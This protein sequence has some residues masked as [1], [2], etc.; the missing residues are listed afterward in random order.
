[1]LQGGKQGWA[2]VFG[3]GGQQLQHQEILE[4]IDS[5]AR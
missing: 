5:D 2:L 3:T 1:M 4:A